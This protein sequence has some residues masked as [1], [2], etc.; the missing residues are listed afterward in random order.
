MRQLAK[1]NDLEKYEVFFTDYGGVTGAQAPVEGGSVRLDAYA[2]SLLGVL[3]SKTPELMR[4]GCSVG[5]G[6]PPFNDL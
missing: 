5:E 4:Q 3:R 6:F 2:I 1:V